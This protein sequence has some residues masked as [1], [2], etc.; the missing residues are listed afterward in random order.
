MQGLVA[1]SMSVEW[2]AAAHSADIHQS[3]ETVHLS[4]L[5]FTL[6]IKAQIN[7]FTKILCLKLP[8]ALKG[9]YRKPWCATDFFIVKEE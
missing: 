1:M 5:H 6:D 8:M 7:T 4:L 3:K 2:A 9:Q